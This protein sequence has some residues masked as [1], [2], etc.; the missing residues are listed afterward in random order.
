MNEICYKPI[1]K[2][3]QSNA[4]L[5]IYIFMAKKEHQCRISALFSHGVFPRS[6]DRIFLQFAPLDDVLDALEKM[7]LPLPSPSSRNVSS[8]GLLLSFRNR[9]FRS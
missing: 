3:P 2:L 9:S 8:I 1:Y 5:F 4:L 7:A 6:L